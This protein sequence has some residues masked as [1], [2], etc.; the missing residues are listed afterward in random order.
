M[1]RFSFIPNNPQPVRK[2]F[3][4]IE[5]LVVIAIIS[6]L[7]AILFPV[8]ARAREN[9]RRTA[10]QSNLKQLGLAMLQYSQDYDERGLSYTLGASPAP[11][12][13]QLIQPYIKSAQVATCPSNF[14]RQI[15]ADSAKQG[16]PDIYTSYAG[17]FV[18]DPNYA[19]NG[20]YTRSLTYMADAGQPGTMM[21]VVV[22]PSK[23]I[24][25]VESLRA[26]S[27]FSIASTLFASPANGGSNCGPDAAASG[28]NWGCMFSHLGMTNF[29]F[30]DGHVKAL[31]PLSTINSAPSQSSP[32]NMWY[33]TGL[34]ITNGALYFDN[35]QKVLGDAYGIND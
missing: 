12:W 29:L 7:A 17:A 18:Q 26:S 20:N 24:F 13:R 11:S 1:T 5:L 30:V 34:G 21:S 32:G 10:C 35:T 22:E 28:Y 8:F 6:L 4:L 27:G 9:A 2:A 16:Y 23:C 31:K 15:K 19:T 14:N 33:K 3:T 25:V